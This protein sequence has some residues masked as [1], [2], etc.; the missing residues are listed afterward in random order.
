MGAEGILIPMVSSVEEARTAVSACKYPPE[1]T[2]GFGPETRLGLWQKKT[3]A[4]VA[5]ANAPVIVIV[6][7]EQRERR[8]PD[9]DAYPRLA[10]H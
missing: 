3:D 10:R 4:Y 8:R 2:R 1:G 7:I 9:V 6:Q 5:Q